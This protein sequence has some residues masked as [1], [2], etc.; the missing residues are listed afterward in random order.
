MLLKHNWPHDGKAAMPVAV[1]V[2]VVVT[3]P[4]QLQKALP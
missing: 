4:A 1:A 3:V 2:A